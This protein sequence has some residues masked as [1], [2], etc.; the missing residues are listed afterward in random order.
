MT[1]PLQFVVGKG[2]VGKSTVAAG[3]ALAAHSRGGRVLA[4]ELEGPGGLAR[5]F[6][7]TPA[8]PGAMVEPRPGLFLSYLEGEAALAEYLG[9]VLP[10][11]R[12]LRTVLAS[13]VYRYFV[14]AAPGLKEL[15]TVGKI[16]YEFERTDPKGARLWDVIVVD[17]GPSG[18][19]LGYLS[20]PK[21]AA[22]TFGSGRV[23]RES[24]RVAAMLEDDESTAVHVVATPEPLPLA[25]AEEIIGELAGGLDLRM[26]GLFIN[27]CRE[28][29]PAGSERVVA[30]A[31]E[32]AHRAEGPG[33]EL[34][35]AL[36]GVCTRA[37]GWERIQE[38]GIAALESLTGRRA[39]RIP[40][41]ASE[42]FGLVE[43]ERSVLPAIAASR[44]EGLT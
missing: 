12:L 37:L 16:F 15:M 40:L 1:R 42:E 13:N 24:L 10:V 2:G 33:N 7:V 9:L 25:E 32:L 38:Q 31:G 17:A 23:Q 3:L 8:S 28:P 34:L 4:L 44:E 6:G 43:L 11:R 30:L 26:G 5:L 20:M 22:A 19:S 41:V 27:R 35:E 18:H 21:A 39:V 29:S 14:A 36:A